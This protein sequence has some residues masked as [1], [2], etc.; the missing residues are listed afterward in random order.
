MISI[1]V[2][3]D[4][5]E[6]KLFEHRAG[7]LEPH[8]VLRRAGIAVERKLFEL[9]ARDLERASRILLLGPDATKSRLHR[10]FEEVRHLRLLERVVG[11]ETDEHP[12][13]AKVIGYS[14]KFFH[15][16]IA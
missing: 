13:A 5:K 16:P 7:E 15:G 10:F 11:I 6:A 4:A 8:S 1:L 3:I 14:R 2:W 9:I 12:T